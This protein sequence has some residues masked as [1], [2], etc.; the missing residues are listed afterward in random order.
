MTK[1]HN[2]DQDIGPSYRLCCR[3]L[4]ALH[5]DMTLAGRE[6]QIWS[7]NATPSTHGSLLHVC[8]YIYRVYSASTPCSNGSLLHTLQPIYVQLHT[9]QLLSVQATLNVTHQHRHHKRHRQPSSLSALPLQDLQPIPLLLLLLPLPL[10]GLWP[11]LL[12]VSKLSMPFPPVSQ[13][14]CNRTTV[15]KSH[16]YPI[17]PEFTVLMQMTIML[18]GLSAVHHRGSQQTGTTEHIKFGWQ[19]HLHTQ[20]L[21]L[22]RSPCHL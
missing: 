7:G 12:V 5:I 6:C 22:P 14:V 9:V 20:T 1:R 4:C 17:T 15:P 16:S 21:V 11:L 3:P 19:P 10:Y 13:V 8:A 2:P 18:L